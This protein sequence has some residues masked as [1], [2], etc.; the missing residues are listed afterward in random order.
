MDWIKRFNNAK[1]IHTNWQSSR[2][3]NELKLTKNCIFLKGL[4]LAMKIGFILPIPIDK[5]SGLTAMNKFVQC[6]KQRFGKKVLVQFWRHS[7]FWTCS[8]R[9][10]PQC[11]SLLNPIKACQRCS[12]STLSIASAL[13][14]N[15]TM[16]NST[17]QFKR[18]EKVDE[19]KFQL[20]GHPAYSPH[21]AP[22][23]YACS[24]QRR[25][26]YEVGALLKLMMSKTITVNF[27]HPFWNCLK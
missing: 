21:L 7:S 19:S 23:D 26:F 24:T 27:S 15:R 3:K 11:L 18:P 9:S 10:Y 12:E 25:K 13:L 6:Q 4:W 16:Q 5:I 2:S 8:R 22:S 20:L 14:F 17:L 1:K